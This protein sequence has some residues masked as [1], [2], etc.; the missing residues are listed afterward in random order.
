MRNTNKNKHFRKEKN[1]TKLIEQAAEAWLNICLYNVK[2]KRL[3]ANQNEN[4]NAYE[5]RTK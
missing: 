4:K 2:Q 3:A 5:Q 1:S